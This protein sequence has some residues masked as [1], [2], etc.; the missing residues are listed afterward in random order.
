MVLRS[1]KRPNGLYML[2]IFIFMVENLFFFCIYRMKNPDI[3]DSPHKNIILIFIILT[4]ASRKG[5]KD[6]C[7][8]Y[9][10]YYI[11]F[12][13]IK[14]RFLWLQ[15]INIPRTVDGPSISLCCIS[16]PC[17]RYYISFVVVTVCIY[18]FI[19]FNL[20]LCVFFIFFEL[21]VCRW[22]IFFFKFDMHQH[23]L[24]FIVNSLKLI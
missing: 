15:S 16:F 13:S 2:N 5:N 12:V 4:L 14:R 10:V 21:R 17:T 6:I 20:F 7:V 11:F 22:L 8:Q 19:S 3:T 1:T 9:C 23:A 18:T 24:N